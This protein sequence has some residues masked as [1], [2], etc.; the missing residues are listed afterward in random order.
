[1]NIIPDSILVKAHHG[2]SKMI[3]ELLC[4]VLSTDLSERQKKNN[5]R[6]TSKDE[7]SR[8]AVGLEYAFIT[9]KS[10]EKSCHK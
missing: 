1:M 6:T 8:S 10:E 4:Q 9:S 3:E 5:N 2:R 7:A